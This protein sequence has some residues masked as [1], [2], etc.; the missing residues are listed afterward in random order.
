[1]KKYS[2]KLMGEIFRLYLGAILFI[3]GVIL[4]SVYL[5]LKHFF[6]IDLGHGFNIP[7]EYKKL[8]GICLLISWIIVMCKNHKVRKR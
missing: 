2:P 5:I 4:I 8:A 3:E 1:M 7:M 6:N